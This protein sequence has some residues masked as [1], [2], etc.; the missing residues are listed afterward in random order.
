MWTPQITIER[1]TPSSAAITNV[2]SFQLNRGRTKISDDFRPGTGTIN[3]RRPDLLPTLKIGDTIRVEIHNPVTLGTLQLDYR[4]ADLIIDYGITSSLD[5]WTLEVED[6]FAYLGRAVVTRTWASGS[7]A[8]DVAVNICSDVGLTLVRNSVGTTPVSAQTVTNA[9]ALDVF[10]TL[11]NT[12]QALVQANA[13][14]LTWYSRG[15]QS[16]IT[17]YA[18]SDTGT[19]AVPYDALTFSSMADNYADKVVV[20]PRGSTEV[21]SGTGIFS[22]NLDSY[23]FDTGQATDLSL[24]VKG[25]FDVQTGTPQSISVLANTDDSAGTDSLRACAV[26]SGI[27]LTFRGLTYQMLVQGFTIT[28]NPT[29]TRITYYVSSTSFYAFLTLNDALLGKLDQNKLGF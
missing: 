9:F 20:Q 24:F 4:V 12:E 28:S 3:G 11:A 14:T 8:S 7:I 16:A 27:S 29:D 26:G 5:T 22:Y 13:T 25:I 19:T 17:Y 23:S 2:Q 21:V 1:V 18:F 6:A 15:W 10:Q